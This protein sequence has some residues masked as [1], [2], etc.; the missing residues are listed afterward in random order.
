MR[1]R[2]KKRRIF[3]EE[4]KK[5]MHDE[6]EERRLLGERIKT[7]TRTHFCLNSLLSLFE[8]WSSVANTDAAAFAFLC[9]HTQKWLAFPLLLRRRVLRIPI[10]ITDILILLI[11]NNNNKEEEEVVPRRR[12]RAAL[13][14][15]RRH[16]RPHQTRI[17]RT[18]T[19]TTT[20]TCHPH[21]HRHR[22]RARP[23]PRHSAA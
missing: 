15:A 23:R 12:R 5:C 3:V 22:E 19:T 13:C 2:E 20:G 8:Q 10:V 9:G 6:K 16:P 18:I 1:E 4:E 14:E 7:H 17:I 21:P 11:N